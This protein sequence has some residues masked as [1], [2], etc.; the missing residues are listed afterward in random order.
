VS[1][2][3]A[4]HSS[5]PASSARPALTA[6]QANPV[7]P[8]A[9]ALRLDEPPPNAPGVAPAEPPS[10]TPSRGPAPAEGAPAAAPSLA[11]ELAMLETARRALVR[12]EPRRTL[13]VLDE[14]AQSFRRPRLLT[15]AAVLRIEAL[16]ASGDRARASRLGKDFLARH[17]NGP[18]ERRVRS[19]IGDQRSASGRTP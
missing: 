1:F 12:G 14:H 16:V 11:D 8:Q 4:A 5:P 3:P 17:G 2:W 15:E 9:P 13:S 19:L 10:V 18:Y 7:A 6:P